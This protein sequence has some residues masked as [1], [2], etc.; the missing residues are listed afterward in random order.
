VQKAVFWVKKN[1][2]DYPDSATE[3]DLQ[4][5]KDSSNPN[6]QVI[7]IN[8]VATAEADDYVQVFWAGDSTQLSVESLPAGTSPVYPA[9]PS[10][11]LTAVQVMYTQV[12]PQGIQGEIGATGATGATGPQGEQGTQ[13]ATGPSGVVDV[14]APITNSGTS[15]SANIGIDQSALSIAASQINNLATG[16]A[17]FLTTPTSANLA[18]AVTNETGSGN[19]VFSASPTFSG[20]VSGITKAMVG[21][22][23]VDNTS[24][25]NKPVSNATNEQLEIVMFE[26][27]RTSADLM[28]LASGIPYGTSAGTISMTGNG[29][30]TRT[31]AV[32]FPSGRFNRAPR[33]TATCRTSNALMATSLSIT[34]TGFTMN[35]R[36]VLDST[37]TTAHSADWQ[38]IQMTSGNASG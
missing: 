31:A 9:V 30:T 38:A 29:A 27:A 24:D 23:N 5:R 1:G 2:V 20:T 15:T 6:R 28:D 32:T 14:T 13:G 25:L 21:L 4:P 36:H 10:I 17:T 22:G 19:L 26:I 7:T 37:F 34:S 8:Y 11:I 16:V 3:M 33:V 12:G 18:A 35:L